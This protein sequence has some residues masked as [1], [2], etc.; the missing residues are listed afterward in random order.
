M[1]ACS[2]KGG[3][4]M[5]KMLSEL[6]SEK[7]LNTLSCYQPRRRGRSMQGCGKCLAS[8]R[9]RG[10]HISRGHEPTTLRGQLCRGYT[11]VGI[12]CQSSISGAGQL[13]RDHAP[14]KVTPDLELG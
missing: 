2:S 7:K 1:C 14:D 11:P 3:V 9:F 5:T 13:C 6:G 8:I 12:Y 10:H 4:D